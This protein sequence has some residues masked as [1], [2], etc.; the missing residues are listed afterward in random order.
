MI[1]SKENLLKIDTDDGSQVTLY[2]PAQAGYMLGEVSTQ[3]IS[4]WRKKGDLKGLLVG[5][6]YYYTR[7]ALE[8][9]AKVRG[10]GKWDR[11]E[12]NVEIVEVKS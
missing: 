3:T 10:L 8:A 2:T 11:S 12:I 5:R 1:H 6:G 4:E 7:P 9:C